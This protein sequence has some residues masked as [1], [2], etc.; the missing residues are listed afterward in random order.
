MISIKDIQKIFKMA[1]GVRTFV[2]LTILR[3]PFDALHTVIHAGFLQ[4]AFRAINMRNQDQLFNVC[5]LFG[6]GSL[7]LFLYNGTVWTL[8][9]AY[10][11][12]WVGKIRRKLFG[13]YPAYLC[14]RLK[15]GHPVNG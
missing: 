1:G 5:F 12:K 13:I 2:I 8:Y 15:Q 7:I 10:V 9:A 14:S 11:T 4:F 3:C 6:I